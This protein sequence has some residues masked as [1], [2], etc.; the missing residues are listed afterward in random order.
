MKLLSKYLEIFLIFYKNKKDGFAK[1]IKKDKAF[2]LNID[3]DIIRKYCEKETVKTF[4][5]IDSKAI[6]EDLSSLITDKST[7]KER[8]QSRFEVLDYMDVI[9]KKYS[10]Y[11]FVTNLNVDYSPKLSLYAL[12]N[13]NTI[14][15]KISKKIF[16]D[17]PL[18]R[19]DIIKVLDQNKQP[20]KKKLNDKWV[21]SEEKEWWI[22]DYKIC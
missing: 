9:D 7:L 4:M 5:G 13:G 8:L 19:G 14:P 18:K 10:G 11:C 6:I 16:K 3:F 22:T 17:K 2:S 21:D 15:V 1:Q 12:A 20:K